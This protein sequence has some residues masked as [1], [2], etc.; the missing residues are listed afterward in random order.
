MA[1]GY[2]VN[3]IDLDDLSE[4]YVNI[5]A[6]GGYG[7]SYS[8]FGEKYD[9]SKYFSKG[10]S[11]RLRYQYAPN[12][13]WFNQYGYILKRDITGYRHSYGVDIAKRGCYPT[14]NM[15]AELTSPG[16]YTVSRSDNAL[17]IG[18]TSYPA[19]SFRNGLVPTLIGIMICSGGGGC[20]GEGYV[21]GDKSGYAVVPGGGGGGGGVIFAVINIT[22][23]IT[24]TIG[25]GG[26]AGS[27]GNSSKRPSSG[28]NGGAGGI[29]KIGDISIPSGDGGGGGQGKSGYV[30]GWFGTGS[31]GNGGNCSSISS[32]S[33]K[34]GIM[35]YK[36]G[37]RGGYENWDGSNYPQKG[38]ATSEKS[39]SFTM[40]GDSSE[41]L[42]SFYS[43]M[44]DN[45]A[46]TSV[47]DTGDSNR[48]SV[49]AGGCSIGSGAAIGI[50]NTKGGG[51]GSGSKCGNYNGANGYCAFYY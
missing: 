34:I 36:S 38:G 21:E 40:A 18:S 5:P 16:S 28:S 30:S 35:G 1:T 10:T 12:R 37:G 31:G 9:F 48:A 43:N 44:F 45:P 39:F 13:S 47:H 26:S 23:P 14:Q 7:L 51:G 8:G 2:L 6:A 3:G 32:S 33:D 19:S 20:G 25:S 4:P 27:N 24:I 11:M 15:F 17:N 42:K 41:Y 22:T 50:Q 49:M 46:T 29:S